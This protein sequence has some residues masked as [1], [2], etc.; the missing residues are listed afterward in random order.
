MN[1]NIF[2]NLL[3]IGNQIQVIEPIAV[4]HTQL[5]WYSTLIQHAPDEVNVL[6]MR[7]QE[8]FPSFGEP[9]DL[10]N[11]EECQRGLSIPEVDWV[12]CNRGLGIPDR[13]HEDD[14]GVVTGPATDELVIRDF[15]REWKRLMSGES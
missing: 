1:L 5:T 2:P 10:A 14:R 12:L 13:H 7:S 11:F 3:V 4:D 9:D 6:R 15:Y 8:D